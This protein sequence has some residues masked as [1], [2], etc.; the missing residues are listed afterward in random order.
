MK[1]TKQTK[2]MV[3]V[4]APYLFRQR[5][6]HMGRKYGAFVGEV[7]EYLSTKTCCNCGRVNE[8]GRSKIHKCV[9]GMKTDRDVA[10]NKNHLKIG[11]ASYIVNDN[12]LEIYHIPAENINVVHNKRVNSYKVIIV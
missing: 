11:Y 4:L 7:S 5:L 10:S 1:I 8:I 9:C 12:D 3:G 2:R 6:G